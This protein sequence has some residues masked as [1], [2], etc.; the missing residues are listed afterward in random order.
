M[1]KKTENKTEELSQK[2]LFLNN[3]LS[4]VGK[5][6]NIVKDVDDLEL[7]RFSTGNLKLDVE[8]KGGYVKGT[9][10]E[11]S[12]FQ[13][14]GKTTSCIEAAREF[15]K[16]YPDELILWVDIEK[17]FDKVYFQR[18]GLDTN[19]EKFIL[20]RTR[21]GE[22]A[23]EAMIEFA[24]SVKGGFIVLDS[25]T[26]LLPEK[27]DESD[28]GQAQMGS[29]ARLMSQGLRKLFPH[30][31]KNETTVFF[32]NQLREKL[33]V[34]FGK[35]T[36]TTGGKSLGFY[37]RTRLENSRVKGEYEDTSFGVNILLEKATFGN[38]KVR[39]NTHMLVEGGF[40]KIADILDLG[41]ESGVLTKAGSWF[42]YGETKIGQGKDATR[43]LLGDNL[44][45][46]QEIES[47]IRKHYEI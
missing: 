26:L 9:F 37:T 20:L 5:G 39:V 32:I 12:G 16:A 11:S 43:E 14:S 13:G 31:S 44:E 29:Q 41:I 10:I 35:N 23:F 42:V 22:E 18:L 7:H 4:K 45:L 2:D 25:V 21:T 1:A 34:M 46:A 6:A 28:M 30:T 8:L 27:E 3:F 40:D 24:K 15:Q 17:V 33:G 47:K 38:E 36:T 19:P